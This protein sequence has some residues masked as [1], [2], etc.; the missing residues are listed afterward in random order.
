[1]NH[2]RVYLLY[3]YDGL[4]PSAQEAQTQRQPPTGNGDLRLGGE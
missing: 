2:K 1:V 4:S 3:R